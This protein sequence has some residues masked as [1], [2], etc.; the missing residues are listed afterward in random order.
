MA[1]T[2]I[3]STQNNDQQLQ[4]LLHTLAEAQTRPEDALRCSCCANPVTTLRQRIS[5]AGAHMHRL[6]NP[7]GMGFDVACFRE[8][9]GAIPRGTAT[10]YYTWF[11]GYTWQLVHCVD[12]GEHLGWYYQT[13]DEHFY[14]LIAHKLHTSHA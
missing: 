2:H 4:Q 11:P 6:Y 1:R 12:C 13:D 5:V 7:H 8:A 3:K 14:G 10:D 9:W